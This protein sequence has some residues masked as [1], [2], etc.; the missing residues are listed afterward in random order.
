MVVV[1]YDAFWAAF[2]SAVEL[3]VVELVVLVEEIVPKKRCEFVYVCVCCIVCNAKEHK[4]NR[5]ER[6]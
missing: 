3:R 4:N 5:R 6:C 1:V 2:W